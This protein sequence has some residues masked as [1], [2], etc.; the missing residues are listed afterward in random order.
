MGRNLRQKRF[1]SNFLNKLSNLVSLI[2]LTSC[3]SYYGKQKYVEKDEVYYTEAKQERLMGKT[4][5]PKGPGP[6]PGVVVV[7]GGGWS[8]RD[9]KDMESISRSLASHGFTVFNINTR[10]SPEF[11][12]PAPILD[13][14]IALDY[15]KAHSQE[16]KLDKHHIGLWGY[17]SGAHI[18]SYYALKNSQDVQAVVSGGA[19]YD[20]SWYP[21]S[22]ITPKYIGKK[23]KDALS[24]YIEASPVTHIHPQA[25]P[26]FI[27]H[28][29]G[30]SLVEFSQ[31]A[32]FEAKL[33][34]SGVRTERY[35]IKHGGHTTGFI[36]SNEAVKRG[37]KFLRREL[38]SNKG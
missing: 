8:S 13:L 29:L 21:Y 35:D 17:S 38:L 4:Y 6:Y 14:G 20:L 26:F 11:H 28:A 36:F 19:P 30:D 25:P 24:D 2:L 7:H 16:L 22:P 18:T 1:R 12:H 10:L 27:Y 23:Y 3:A 5:V 31:A 9:Y 33:K 15:F 34:N 32:S 37:I